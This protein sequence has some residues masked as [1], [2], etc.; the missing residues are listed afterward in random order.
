MPSPAVQDAGGVGATPSAEAVEAFLMEPKVQAPHDAARDWA[1]LSGRWG[2]QHSAM[3]DGLAGIGARG[4]EP[5]A[6]GPTLADVQADRDYER[7]R[8]NEAQAQLKAIAAALDEDPERSPAWDDND[9]PIP[10]VRRVE[11]AL[12]PSESQQVADLRASFRGIEQQ[13]GDVDGALHALGSYGLTSTKERLL[14]VLPVED[15]RAL[16]E[17]DAA[18]LRASLAR[19]KARRLNPPPAE[20]VAEYQ[21][22]LDIV[23]AKLCSLDHVPDAG[24]MVNG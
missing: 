16:L 2:H 19:L 20:R 24:K 23:E 4:Q 5:V 15:R 21:R 18:E 10:L 22:K 13:L 17:L 6:P 11:V 12:M 9:Q 3:P 1:D 8:A 14:Q 7:R